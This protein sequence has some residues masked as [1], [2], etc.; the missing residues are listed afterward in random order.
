MKI[1][2]SLAVLLLGGCARPDYVSSGDL[3][4][5]MD[6]HAKQQSIMF[7][8]SQA[9]GTLEWLTPPSSS[10]ASSLLLSFA[11]PLPAELSA[12]LWMPSMGHGSAPVKIEKLDETHY[13]IT[14]IYFIMPGDWEV[15]LY[16]KKN[17][18]TVDEL[19]IPLMVP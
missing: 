11:S 8:V 4:K 5:Q 16:L 10:E 13:R 1:F 12:L 6:P 19:F 18:Q 9:P 7:P 2:F 17:S 14:N 3:Q 15:R